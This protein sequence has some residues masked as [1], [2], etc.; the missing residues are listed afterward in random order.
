MPIFDYKCRN[1]GSKFERIVRSGGDNVACPECGCDAAERQFSG[2]AVGRA[3]CKNEEGC[4][5]SHKCCS[6]NC[7][8]RH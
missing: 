3:S 4:A 6:D 7:C 1:C 5:H 2:F 8:H